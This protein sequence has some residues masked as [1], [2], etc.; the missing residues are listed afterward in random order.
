MHMH[1]A[2]SQQ[3]TWELAGG[4]ALTLPFVLDTQRK[5]DAPLLSVYFLIFLKSYWDVMGKG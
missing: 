1:T 5:E 3:K 2:G 4:R